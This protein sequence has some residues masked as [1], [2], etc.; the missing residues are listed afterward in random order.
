MSRRWLVVVAALG[1]ACGSRLADIPGSDGGVQGAQWTN[2]TA[3]LAGMT[4]ECGNMTFLSSRPD[5]DMLIAGVAKQGLWTKKSADATWTRLGQ[6]AGSAVITNRPSAIVYD[7]AHL[8][9]FWESGIYNA[10]AA[11]RTDDNGA[12]FVQLGTIT[13]SDLLSVDL[14]DS[15]RRTML[16]G[17]HEQIATLYRSTDGGANW[18]NIGSLLPAGAG[19]SS[20]PQVIDSQTHLIGTWG[21]T[22]SGVFRTTNGGANWTR[23]YP[24]GVRGRPL[25]ASD[26]SIYWLVENDGGIIRSADSGANWTL[27]AGTGIFASSGEGSSLAELP[28]GRIISVG[29]HEIIYSSDHGVTWRLT[30]PLL[31]FAPTGVAYSKFAQAIYAWH[32]D[33]SLA[34]PAD[35]IMRLDFP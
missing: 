33:C 28:D 18:A 2:V 11:Y 26:N 30:G 8:D 9:T 3:N 27:T 15:Q 23:V 17:G 13:H 16:A 4:S 25:I 7:P 20:F 24:F 10:G 35:G 12:T 5:R 29:N 1:A 19:N 32:F 31:S 22:A 21:G 14:S 6:G 34:V